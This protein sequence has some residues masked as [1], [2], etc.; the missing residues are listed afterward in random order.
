MA[1]GQS[2]RDIGIVFTY[3][4]NIGVPAK[5]D[6]ALTI[7]EGRFIIELGIVEDRY[8]KALRAKGFKIISVV[9]R[10]SIPQPKR[11][12]GFCRRAQT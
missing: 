12:D 2:S 3:I 5:E 11:G 1:S 8:K 4:V 7:A 10:I 6:I 9:E